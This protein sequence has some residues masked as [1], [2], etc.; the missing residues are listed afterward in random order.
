MY[1]KWGTLALVLL[2]APVLLFAQNTGKL[3]GRVIDKS[4]GEPLPGATVVL[5]GTQMGASADENGEYFII[6]IPVGT[7]DVRASFVGYQPVVIRGVEINAGYT[8]EL[9]F[10][11]EPSEV[12]LEEIV[13]EYERPLIQK[14]AIGVP[15]VVTSEEI[16]NLPVRGVTEIAGLQGGVVKD[17]GSGALHIR[18]GR[19]EEVVYYVDGVKVTGSIG[20]PQQAIQEQEMLI[21]GL[22]A[23]YGDALS[24]VISL[25]TRTGAPKFYGS[26][27]GITSQALD[28]YGYNLGSFSL[29]G[30]I[31]KQKLSFFTAVEFTSMADRNPRAI[32]VPQISDNLY[33]QIQQNP[34][35]LELVNPETGEVRYATLPGSLA[36]SVN[37]ADFRD[38]LGIPE[39]FVLG[40]IAPIPAPATF[41]EDKF[42]FEKAKPNYGSKSLNF[43]GNLTFTPTASIRF[44]LGANIATRN[45]DG[46]SHARVLYNNDRNFKNEQATN[47][48]YGSWTHYLSQST[49]YQLNVSFTDFK[50]YY[51][52]P[53]FSN[54]IRDVLFYGDIDH[55]ANVIASRYKTVD[56]KD[57]D[58]DSEIDT[59]FVRT[60]R[61]GLVPNP[62]GLYSVMSLP[63][64][65]RLGYGKTHNRQFYLSANAT[66]QLGIHQIEFGG[67]YEQRTNRFYAHF[68]GE[69]YRL[70][71]FFDDGNPEAG[72][73][74]AVDRYDDL[75]FQAVKRKI[76]YYGY[77]Y[78][79][80]NE[81]DNQDVDAFVRGENF[82][83]APWRP[84]YYAGYVQ[85]KIEYKDIVLNL[86]VRVDVFDNNT[87]VPKDEYALVPIIRANSIADRP[88]NIGPDYAVYFAGDDVV[89]YRD[90]DGRFYDVRGQQVNPEDIVL[91]GKP[92]VPEGKNPTIASEVFKDYEPQVTVMPRIG[93]SF[94]ITDQALFFAHYDVLS[95]RPTENA[96]DTPYEYSLAAEG[97]RTVD[98]PGLKPEKTIEYELG[99]RQR[100]GAKAA[101]T[102]SGFYRQIKNKIQLRTVRYGFPNGYTTY[103]NV[104]FGTVK[105]V[106]FE[107]DLRRTNNVSLNA[108]YTLQFAQGTGSDSRT[109][110]QIAWRG[111]YFPDFIFP[112]D[113]DQRHTINLTI[114][115]RL[116][117]GEG[118]V[119]F[120]ARVFENFGFNLV[121]QLASGH[122]YTPLT[123]PNPIYNAFIASPKG[124]LNSAYMPWRSLINLR[125]D[126]KFDLSGKATLTAYLWIQ[127]LLDSDNVLDVYRAT[128]LPDNDGYLDTGEGRDWLTSQA[129]PESA[130]V[131]YQFRVRNPF[132]YG[133]P[134]MTRLGVR[135]DF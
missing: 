114:D 53:K 116:G 28:A 117:K 70:A 38:Q 104:D 135:I 58:G 2:F 89:G 113:F 123:A 52:D 3:A 84:V 22:P 55:E 115:Y 125:L 73:D 12:M 118:P 44:R 127:N 7:Y 72:Q 67:E 103:R 64:A 24:G 112:L 77:D 69:A 121:T 49:F 131:H 63:G 81:V 34:Q 99:F 98:N 68:S 109:T 50:A 119:L 42:S 105:G 21:G 106:E 62:V 20:V 86:G 18:G 54:D 85:D 57:V 45:F 78:L 75:D 27:E 41:L 100:V 6:G 5:E 96:F 48:F 61:D 80:L 13:V 14:D 128:G 108:N 51:Y 4:T 134:R 82:N 40:S 11:L 59:I 122:P 26:L 83:M 111:N 74:R 19:S 120:G 126:R 133:I 37:L 66:T 30:P 132:N 92:K 10:E 79:G 94:P 60:Y 97:T 17:E 31:L 9:N 129:V 36:D 91:V 102:I 130:R 71:A 8:R 110:A 47:R 16:Q 88:D 43:N 90:L 32:P 65:G 93:V 29:G 76:W 124:E 15:K 23:K 25:T 1:R 35:V 33:K 95:S 56:F 87:L 107:F 101:L 46:Y 39:G